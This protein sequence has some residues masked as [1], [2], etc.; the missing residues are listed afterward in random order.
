[1]TVYAA[2][3]LGV[4]FGAQPVV[5][6]LDFTVDAGECLALVGESG[7]GKSQCC[8][9]PFG[10]SGGHAT[11]SARLSGQELIGLPEAQ[12]RRLRGRHAGFVFQQPL[13]ALTPHLT[14]GR[15]LVEAMEQ[16]DGIAAGHDALCAS[17]AEVGIDRPAE[18]LRQYPHQ[19]SGGQRQRAMIAMAVAHNPR[20]LIADEPT[21]ALD[22][23]LRHEIL[24][25]I[26]R[27]RRERGLAVI[28]VSHDL[29]LVAG[30]ADRVLVMQA[31]RAVEQGPART[32]LAR[33]ATDYARALAAA[34]PRMDSPPPVLPPVGEELL[35]ARNI[36]VSFR[37]PGWRGGR[38]AAV[39][40]ASFGLREGEAVALIG[41][42]GSGKSTLARAV[43]RLG[44]VDGG[45]VLWLGSPL[46]SRGKLDPAR[47]RAIQFVAQD[48]VDSLDPRWSAGRSVGEGVD[49]RARTADPAMVASLLGEV[50][51]DPVLADRRPG[52][53][54]GG[55]AQRVAI[56]RALAADPALLVCDEATSALDVTIQ[57]QVVALL[58]RLQRERRLAMLFISHDL[59]LVRQLCHRLVV[60]DQG[61]VVEAG[62]TQA[63]LSSPRSPVTRALI[64]ASR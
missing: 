50:G 54:S 21:T 37:R 62:E 1:M 32:L 10:L 3:D 42:S 18:R 24:S 2:S 23:M 25:L 7:S 31:G 15:Q 28:L 14:I 8:L 13:S 45:S 55:Q 44:P 46:P 17:L 47:R 39:E 63:V 60:M 6:G 33:P 52:A 20:L 9:A 36:R 26:G 58:A 49:P 40:G 34:A 64:A 29:A 16:G 56:A 53:L 48:P 22:A 19:L 57:A 11:G 5:H 59:A 27:L 4:H 51:L 43:A 30:H 35:S 61:R 41:G 12:L 38:I